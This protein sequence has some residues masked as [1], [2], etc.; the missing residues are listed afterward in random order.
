MSTRLKMGRPMKTWKSRQGHPPRQ[1]PR[2]RCAS[3]KRLRQPRTW[4][5]HG[6]IGWCCSV[7]CGQRRR[8]LKGHA[9]RMATLRHQAAKRAHIARVQM[10]VRRQFGEFSVR[11][12]A[13]FQFAQKVGYA[14]G[15]RAS[16]RK[17]AR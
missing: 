4:E 7:S 3:C 17:A 15:Y 6:R 14:R 10:L 9:R 12:I 11:D 8:C 5:E 1:I 2:R 13:V 16:H